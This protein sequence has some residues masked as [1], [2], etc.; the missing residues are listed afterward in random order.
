MR[1]HLTID[2]PKLSI[3]F[4]ELETIIMSMRDK[5]QAMF[6]TSFDGI[7]I[8]LSY[9]SG[10]NAPI[11][12]LQSEIDSIN[13]ILKEVSDMFGLIQ[14][15]D[16]VRNKNA[17]I[18]AMTSIENQDAMAE[19]IAAFKDLMARAIGHINLSAL[20]CNVFQLHFTCIRLGI[21][22]QSFFDNF[23]RTKKNQPVLDTLFETLQTCTYVPEC[24]PFLPLPA[25]AFIIDITEEVLKKINPQNRK[26]TFSYTY[27]Q[28]K[29]D[30][31]FIEL[32]LNV[33][34]FM[35]FSSDHET[36]L[37]VTKDEHKF[38]TELAKA[39]IL[40]QRE[41]YR[42]K[43]NKTNKRR[44]KKSKAPNTLGTFAQKNEKFSFYSAAII[45]DIKQNKNSNSNAICGEIENNLPKY[46]QSVD[47]ILH[48]NSTEPEHI[49][50]FTRCQWYNYLETI[51]RHIDLVWD[52]NEKQPDRLRR[53][54]IVLANNFL[55]FYSHLKDI[56][57]KF[58]L[59]NNAINTAAQ[60]A[61]ANESVI[62]RL[63][64][65]IDKAIAS[66]ERAL[67][68]KPNPAVTEQTN[69]AKTT[70]ST[71]SS[72]SEPD[73]QSTSNL[74]SITRNL[75]GVKE[76][77]NEL[78]RQAD[79][80]AQ[81]NST[82]MLT[83]FCGITPFIANPTFATRSQE[84]NV[85]QVK[86]RVQFL[87]KLADL[88]GQTHTNNQEPNQEP[89][90]Y[91]INTLEQYDKALSVAFINNYF[92][93]IINLNFQ[94]AYRNFTELFTTCQTY[95]FDI[96][97]KTSTNNQDEFIKALFYCITLYNTNIQTYVK[98]TP[99][100]SNAF[101]I[102]L[103]ENLLKEINS[104]NNI[105]YSYSLDSCVVDKNYLENF[106]A[107]SKAIFFGSKADGN[108]GITQQEYELFI[109]LVKYRISAI[110]INNCNASNLSLKT[111]NPI[112]Q[113][114]I[115]INKIRNITEI[116]GAMLI[117]TAGALLDNTLA[118]NEE[119]SERLT[120][121]VNFLETEFKQTFSSTR[122][123]FTSLTKTD[124][125]KR[126]ILEK[127]L[128]LAQRYE[129]LLT[130]HKVV[131]DRWNATK[132][133]S[134]E[135]R[136]QY[137]AVVECLLEL[138]AVLKQENLGYVFKTNYTKLIKEPLAPNDTILSALFEEV[139]IAIDTWAGSLKKDPMQYNN[140]NTLTTD[141]KS[142]ENFGNDHLET[143]NMEIFK[144]ELE[145]ALKES[146]YD[147][148][149][150]VQVEI[151]NDDL[152]PNT[153]SKSSMEFN[154][155]VMIN[156]HQA[157]VSSTS[158]IP[159]TFIGDKFIE[160]ISP[161]EKERIRKEHEELE[162]KKRKE[163]ERKDKE[164]E[165]KHKTNALNAL[166]KKINKKREMLKIHD[167]KIAAQNELIN[168]LN[169][170]ITVQ[171]EILAK[172]NV[173]SERLE[174]TIQTENELRDKFS[175]LN[176]KVDAA[177]KKVELCKDAESQAK[178]K[179]DDIKAHIEKLKKD[180][181][182]K[183]KQDEANRL[184]VLAYI[185]EKEEEE[186]QEKLDLA[187]GIPGW[188]VSITTAESR[189]ILF[190]EVALLARDQGHYCYALSAYTS[191]IDQYTSI[192]SANLSCFY[193]IKGR[194]NLSLNTE[195]LYIPMFELRK[196]LKCAT[197]AITLAKAVVE[198]KIEPYE[199]VKFIFGAINQLFD[200]SRGNTIDNLLGGMLNILANCIQ[201]YRSLSSHN[202]YMIGHFIRVE[203]AENI[204]A[205]TTMSLNQNVSYYLGEANKCSENLHNAL[206]MYRDYSDLYNK[207]FALKL[208]I[209]PHIDISPVQKL[210]T[211]LQY[212]AQL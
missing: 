92:D 38:Y 74:M 49:Q 109:E 13:A 208:E 7:N 9:P 30:E 42:F 163:K 131:H 3:L 180:I 115:S 160:S 22:I 89:L 153:A 155:N 52:N 107:Q 31:N 205:G 105:D 111:W 27:N 183:N 206:I 23:I 117:Y 193:E 145:K 164:R 62:L 25:I 21:D 176:E 159:Q 189:I 56:E 185:K 184:E 201:Y 151:V 97:N 141:T 81:Y 51:R 101:I 178:T 80:I 196:A 173:A 8:Y 156:E 47:S 174:A 179:L 41:V 182:E 172:A 71:S 58:V 197:S 55:D 175:L 161:G 142:K 20:L 88:L 133:P 93:A 123:A 94:I 132:T 59:S 73:T 85:D 2:L 194:L 119:I 10:A 203:F 210:T 118:I 165:I 114:S 72:S 135:L 96:S 91:I 170:E 48:E 37:G 39:K 40:H 162:E 53:A 82:Y 35:Y 87:G 207:F 79:E 129:Y 77:I 46:K 137:I 212:S 17:I 15:S 127:M 126:S 18:D 78:K 199:N 44:D 149:R 108:L 1:A 50:K 68:K 134:L 98:N 29:A 209:Q 138:F 4:E 106:L 65:P 187:V 112:E 168:K 24:I 5:T 26:N 12:M 16:F 86:Q 198:L 32:A 154:S 144:K 166:V 121:S 191:M 102:F 130:I 195:E 152:A 84:F 146:E 167:E 54:Y 124:W 28:V 57:I 148:L 128:I 158:T 104:S 11:N 192:A 202:T 143:F 43:D 125:D 34:K 147:W 95:G 60:V 136:R 116:D 103:A 75:D 69:T 100:I 63:C 90:I 200:N 169:Q 211:L 140:K 61:S 83:S 190:E 150:D 177:N 67:G 188:I 70:T 139:G 113:R 122:D 33:C 181:K 120:S 64:Q 66:V 14:H 76:A 204:M 6:Y 36:Q 19:P 99:I 157:S 171:S 45:F 110:A 186:L